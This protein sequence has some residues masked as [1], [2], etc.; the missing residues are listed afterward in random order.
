MKPNDFF[1]GIIDF[2]A[3]LLPGACGVAIL[4]PLFTK[5]FLDEIISLPQSSV[6]LWA[7]F[8]VLSYFLGHLIFLTGSS[9]DWFYNKV[10]EK[11]NPY[12][13]ESAYHCAS[14]LRKNILNELENQATNTFQWSRAILTAFF[15]QA[16]N[17]IYRLEA[18]SKFFRSLIVIFFMATIILLVREKYLQSVISFILTIPCSFRYYERRL[19]GTTL[20]YQYV[21]TF[22]RLGKITSS[23]PMK[24]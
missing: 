4:E 19:K 22:Y 16:A 12:T 3:I 15:P 8:M 6:G 10:R 23:S 5:H 2:F 18:D 20:A 21:I 11:F 14:E 7:L 9:L 24:T 13:N 1:V 17:D